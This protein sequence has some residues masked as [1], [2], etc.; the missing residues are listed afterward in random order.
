MDEV[1]GVTPGAR[2]PMTDE[3]IRAVTIGEMGS[4]ARITLAEYDPEWPALYAREAERIRAALGER[5]LLL[6]HVGSTSVPGLAAKPRIDILLVVPDSADE[7]GYVP[8]LGAAGYVL[9]IREPEWFEHRMFKGPDTAVNLHVLSPGC[10]ESERMLRFRDH[11]RRNE[12]DRQLYERT[13]R[14]LAGRVWRHGQNYADAK[15]DVIDE[16]LSRAFAGSGE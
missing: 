3:Q 5:V 2:Q 9:H 14:M 11:L 4:P 1:S 15:S 12:G 7:P 13:K 16:I 6:E 10:T 8:D